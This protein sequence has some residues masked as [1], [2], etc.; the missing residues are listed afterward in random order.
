MWFN[1]SISALNNQEISAFPSIFIAIV[2]K[3]RSFCIWWKWY[4]FIFTIFLLVLTFLFFIGVGDTGD[5]W[6]V[7][8]DGDF[9]ER[10]DSVTFKHV[11]TSAYLA[12]SG[13]NSF[14]SNLKSSFLISTFQ[15]G[16]AYGR[17][18]NGQLEIVGLPRLDSSCQWQT[19]EGLFIH[20]SN[21]NPKQSQNRPEHNELWTTQSFS[22][23][24]SS[25]KKQTF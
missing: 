12:T 25:I 5:Y 14:V 23:S 22:T 21:F 7:V 19:A 2:R 13:M 18:I 11:D 9:W 6:K 24:I 1:H 20:T 15:L 8:C 17:P 4:P 3:S 10:D 16:H